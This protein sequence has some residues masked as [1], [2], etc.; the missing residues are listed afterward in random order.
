MSM[1]IFLLIRNCV[2]VR[3]LLVSR[4]CYVFVHLGFVRFVQ[5]QSVATLM[6]KYE[7]SDVEI[8]DVSVSIIP[9]G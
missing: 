9:I 6:K 2:R 1:A 7:A 3:M 5:P 8:Q 4:P